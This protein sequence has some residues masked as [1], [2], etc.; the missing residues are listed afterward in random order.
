MARLMAPLF[1]LALLIF[2]ATAQAQY[3]GRNK[4]QYEHFDFKVLQTDHFDVYFYPNEREAADIASR[5]PERWY[6]RLS[7]VMR[8]QLRG[9]Q[10]L[11]LYATAPQFRQT[12]IVDNLGE[13]TGGVTEALR[14]RIVLPIGGT[15]ADLNHVIGHE[16]THAFQYDMTGRSGPEGRGAVPAA[17]SLPLWFIE[18]M[19]EYM[20]LGAVAPE[21][22]MWMRGG[23]E[24]TL[25]SFRQLEDPRFF[26]YRYGHALLAYVAGRWGDPIMGDLLGASI[27]TRDIGQA[28]RGVLAITPDQLVQEWHAATA[29][30]YAHLEDHTEPAESIGVR[31]VKAGD[32]SHGDGSYNIGP[33]LSPDGNRFM[34]LSDR[35]LFSIDLFLADGRTGKVDRQI[36]RTAVN[37]HFQSLQ[38]IESA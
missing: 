13:G 18:G 7:T 29:Q 26:P 38:F 16:L 6:T 23:L 21:T 24:D 10:P 11:I 8:H 17:A 1:G 27:R 32:G 15:L 4:V 3:F 36:T 9:R 5:M 19:A 20:S 35:D 22:A 14:R 37:P 25:P 34:F 30:A 33:A 31:L 12:N 2:P 28:I